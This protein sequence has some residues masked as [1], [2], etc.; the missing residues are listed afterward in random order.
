MKLLIVDD[1][2][3][4]RAR[5]VSLLQDHPDI[6]SMAEAANG[7]EAIE[8]Y[9]DFQPDVILMDIRMPGMDGL[10]AARH[11][12]QLESAPIIIF[13]TAYDDHA[14]D[15][16][17]LN[18]IGYLL[19]PVQRDKLLHSL[20]TA[21]RLSSDQMSKLPSAQRKFIS[22]QVAGKLQ[23]VAIDE[24]YYFRAEQKYVVASH[25]NGELLLE[26]TLKALE[27]ELSQRFIRIHRSAL[28]AMDKIAA[29]VKTPSGQTVLTFSGIDDQIEVSRRHL[30]QVRKT[31]KQLS[32]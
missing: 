1:E 16:Y 30:P 32:Q 31:I 15:A 14:L 5:L 6:S 22:A 7:L 26:E 28:V 25:A 12:A 19:K 9:K 13:T 20:A 10:E 21:N 24:V 23:M 2:P 17:D 8:Q 27:A 3:L 11:L 29:L 4:A 18:A